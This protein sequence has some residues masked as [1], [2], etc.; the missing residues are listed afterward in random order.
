MKSSISY[1]S[2]K[3]FHTKCFIYRMK[4]DTPLC[5]I[6]IK[7][8]IV[9]KS[10]LSKSDLCTFLHKYIL[11]MGNPGIV[12][13]ILDLQIMLPNGCMHGLQPYPCM[14]V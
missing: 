14:P 1:V 6:N 11:N 5:L 13:L 12:F 4:Q 8:Q 3:D 10:K 2:I 9:M 7:K